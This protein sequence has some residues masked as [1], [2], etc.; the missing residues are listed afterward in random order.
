MRQHLAP[1]NAKHGADV[2]LEYVQDRSLLALQGP[3]AAEVDIH[4]A[5]HLY[6]L[7]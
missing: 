2:T 3:K 1:F 5:L 7:D 4:S 6:F